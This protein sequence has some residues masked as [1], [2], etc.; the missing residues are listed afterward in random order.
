MRWTA[1]IGP[2]VHCS[3]RPPKRAIRLDESGQETE[4]DVEGLA[5]EDLVRV[6][7]GQAFPA[8]GEISKGRSASDESTLTG[9]AVPV[10]KNIGDQVFSGTINL[11]GSVDFS[12]SKLP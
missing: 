10:E 4:V 9:E 3:S 5:I 12:V 1:R 6:R 2:S 8:D 7:P 11:W